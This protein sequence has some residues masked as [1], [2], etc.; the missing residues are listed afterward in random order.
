MYAQQKHY[1]RAI[2]SFDK[3]LALTGPDANTYRGRGHAY[4]RLGEI[5]KAKRDFQRTIELAP[6]NAAN[7]TNMG[8]IDARLGSYNAAVNFTK[9]A[10]DLDPK[11]SMA[12]ELYDACFALISDSK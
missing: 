8:L 2:K 4:E 11:D 3:A 6:K 9:K 1:R 7:W 10:L 12:K 5:K